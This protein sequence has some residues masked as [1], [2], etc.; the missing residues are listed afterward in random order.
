MSR[1]LVGK[2]EVF[3]RLEER[4]DG[5]I[6]RDYQRQH[7]L[8]VVG[9]QDPRDYMTYRH[10]KVLIDKITQSIMNSGYHNSSFSFS[11][12][13]AHQDTP[14]NPLDNSYIV[15]NEVLHAAALAQAGRGFTVWGAELPIRR[16]VS[17]LRGAGFDRFVDE[18]IRPAYDYQYDLLQDYYRAASILGTDRARLFR[19][20]RPSIRPPNEVVAQ[21]LDIYPTVFRGYSA[22]TKEGN[23]PVFGSLRD[24]AKEKML[25]EL[26]KFLG[27]TKL[28]R[29]IRTLKEKKAGNQLFAALLLKKEE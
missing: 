10:E 7:L 9:P 11:T 24:Y 17:A 8:G 26:D 28:D 2:R 1:P 25:E 5:R 27:L 29:K 12:Y 6:R 22:I 21:Y 14:Y 19:R 18:Y 3:R 13:Y 20:R 4:S 23:Q 16:G 15:R